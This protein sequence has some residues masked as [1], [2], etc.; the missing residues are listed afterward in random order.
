MPVNRWAFYYFICRCLAVCRKIMEKRCCD[1]SFRHCC[2]SGGFHLQFNIL[3][4]LMLDKFYSVSVFQGKDVANF[5]RLYCFKQAISFLFFF[6]K[7]GNF[8]PSLTNLMV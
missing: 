8:D 2:L 4:A 7:G 5:E 1:I 3:S 6:F